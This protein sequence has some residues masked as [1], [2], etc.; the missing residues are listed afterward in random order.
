MGARSAIAMAADYYSTLGVDPGASDDQVRAAYR[1]LAWRLHPDR[2]ASND[3]KQR[4][5]ALTEAYAVLGQRV[6]RNAYDRSLLAKMADARPGKL[7]PIRCSDCGRIAVQPRILA[8]VKVKSYL[9]WFTLRHIEGVFCAACGRKAA[10]AASLYTACFGWWSAAGPL[11]TVF[12]IIRNALGGR[13][14]RASDYGLL[15]HNAEA[16]LAIKDA[17]LAYTLARQVRESGE[18][19]LA[20]RALN[21]MLQAKRLDATVATGK[22]KDP[23]KRTAYQVL[24]HAG[25]LFA[26]PVLLIVLVLVF[27]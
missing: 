17:R 21:T 9:I 3:A 16:F 2:N 14:S 1:K 11:L 8:F 10:W 24:G 7:R 26:G 5:Q 19:T 25:L 4:F 20:A 23:W 18:S 12:A 13:R 22:L 27:R 15:Q 6:H